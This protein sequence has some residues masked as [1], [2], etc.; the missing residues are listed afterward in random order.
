MSIKKRILGRTG[1]E[2]SEIGF[3][4]WAIG[5]NSYG[6]VEESQAKR[7]LHTYIEAGGNFIDKAKS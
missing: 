3:G 7:C 4:A 2:I 1:M 5:G 6:M